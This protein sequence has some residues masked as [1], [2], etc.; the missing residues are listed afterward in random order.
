[1]EFTVQKTENCFAD[2]QTY[3]YKLPLTGDA[4][5]RLLDADWS[6][7]INDKLRRPVF[8]A[9]R[10]DLRLKGVLAETL[11]RASFPSAHALEE[12]AAFEAWLRECNV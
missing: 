1:M 2:A 7:R 11:V 3:E 12:K 5:L 9:E 10:Q 8:I 4:L 6:I